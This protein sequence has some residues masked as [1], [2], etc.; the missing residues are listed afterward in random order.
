MKIE[1][2]MDINKTIYMCD[3]SNGRSLEDMLN[4]IVAEYVKNDKWENTN[5]SML[6][7]T[8]YLEMIKYPKSEYTDAKERKNLINHLKTNFTNPGF[9]GELFHRMVNTM[10]SRLTI[11]PCFLTTEK[12]RKFY[13]DRYYKIVP[14]FFRLLLH[15]SKKPSWSINLRT[16]GQDLEQVIEELDLFCNGEHPLFPGIIS[17][18][19]GNTVDLRIKERG[20]FTYDANNVPILQLIDD[21]FTLMIGHQQI[22]EYFN[23]PKHIGIFAFQ[24]DYKHWFNQNEACEFGKLWIIDPN[25]TN[26]IQ[27]F[28]DDNIET[29]HAHIVNV[30]DLNT[31]QPISFDITKDKYLH[32]IH[33]F[34]VIEDE[35]Y[36]I[37]TLQ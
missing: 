4:V 22:H 26:S 2:H 21:N 5:H 18:G 12:Q 32:R 28:Y 3:P 17:N 20:I 14:S 34:N 27:K 9:I 10:K 8:D 15:L 23:D 35:S 33:P 31:Y 11:P 25:E 37:K 7:Y 24:D 30:R 29:D 36:F 19:T 16:F 6:T 13:V 1:L